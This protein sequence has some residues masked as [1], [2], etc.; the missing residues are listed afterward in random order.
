M[1]LRSI[2][3]ACALATLPFAVVAQDK[4]SGYLC[5]NMRTDGSWISDI[6]YQES[7][8]RLIPVGTP[9]TVL[10][11]GR[12]RV[13]TQMEGYGKQWLGN[14]YSRELDLG[15][16][17][18]RYVVA[19]DPKKK[20]ATFTPRVR[21]AIESARLVPGMTREQVLMSVGYPV[22]SENPH[23]DAKVWRMWMSSFGE[24][25]VVFEGD[26]VKEIVTNDPL[27]RNLVLMD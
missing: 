2:T 27:T 15:S 6:N 1:T 3:A 9:T 7:G 24:F 11:Y 18:Q 25:Q 4:T 21:K 20:L 17:A 22:T 14:D 23:L 8:K 10:G 19:D 26:R 5:C 13:E 16:F 12:Q